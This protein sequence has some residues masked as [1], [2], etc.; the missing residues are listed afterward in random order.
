[1]IPSTLV[2]LVLFAASIGPGYVYVRVAE[3]REP[4]QERSP[5][6]EAAEL[7]FVGVIATSTAVLLGIQLAESTDLI[8]LGPLVDSPRDYILDHPL[9]VLG[10]L[11]I[12]FVLSYGGAGLA[13]RV[14]HW[15][16][17]PMIKPGYSAW[18]FVLADEPGIHRPYTT[19]EL[20]D[21]RTLAGWIGGFTIE[22]S[23]PD[24]RELILVAPLKIKEAKGKPF[25]FLR[26]DSIVLQGSDILALSVQTHSD[27][28]PK[29]LSKR[30]AEKVR[31]ILPGHP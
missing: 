22:P 31:R 29:T 20:R 15:S 28:R 3:R 17:P 12:L 5:L 27:P 24:K 16:A 19:V 14:T 25:K 13:A 30:V 10:W 26:D 9:R 2:G 1:V 11:A 18:D 8:D 21:G 6:L 4:R 23:D 7:V